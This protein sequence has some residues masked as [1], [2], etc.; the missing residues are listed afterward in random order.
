MGRTS[1]R[2]PASTDARPPGEAGPGT[3]APRTVSR[4]R[5][6]G[7]R[8]FETALDVPDELAPILLR[9]LSVQ[10]SCELVSV[11]Q[12]RGWLNLA[13]TI[14][15]RWTM[16]RIIADETRHGLEL[17]RLLGDFG[18]E[19]ARA[20]DDVLAATTDTIPAPAFR[21]SLDR[22][23]D[24]AVFL[25]LIDRVGL[26]QNDNLSDACYAPLARAMP[27]M[28]REEQLHV[29]VGTRLLTQMVR[30]GQVDDV[31]EAIERWL[32][33]AVGMFGPETSAS[34]TLAVD[35]GLK[36]WDNGDARDR[37]LTAV[38]GAVEDLGVP[39]RVPTARLTPPPGGP[40]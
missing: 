17:C 35:G 37:Y 6:A 16:A 12:F 10:A 30:A 18:E 2:G 7:M 36:R 8:R 1:E 38:A 25:Y 22:W 39:V 11:Q 26:A 33:I 20:V 34:A 21:I 13:P 23:V 29:G 3:T 27:Q 32:P 31:V 15:D 24:V 4:G 5:Y 19:G 28:R 14:E 40:T 9:M